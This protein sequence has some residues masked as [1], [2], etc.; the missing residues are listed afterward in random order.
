MRA[1][2]TNLLVRLATRDDPKQ[3][4]AAEAFVTGGAWV[5]HVVLVEFVWVLTSV[6]EL[7]HAEIVA[8]IDILLAHEQL[9]LQ[10]PE[11]IAA[12]V[13]QLR[14]H[15]R[16]SFSDCLVLELARK[17]GHLPLGTFDRDLAKLPG[18]ERV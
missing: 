8:A 14:R 13:E 2:D 3:V 1:V 11:T 15:R 16:T 17:A 10:D 18:T 5:S 9:T 4:A 12:A 7:G 6:Y